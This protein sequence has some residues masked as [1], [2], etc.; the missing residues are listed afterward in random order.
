M[1]CGM[2][3]PRSTNVG[4]KS[5]LADN[6]PMIATFASR[7]KLWPLEE[8]SFATAFNTSAHSGRALPTMRA[9][10]RTT[11]VPSVRH[12]ATTL[13]TRLHALRPPSEMAHNRSW[14]AAGRNRNW[15][16]IFHFEVP[17]VARGVT[18]PAI[19]AATSLGV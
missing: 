5:A 2:F 7:A 10:A 9:S 18:A 17:S 16:L 13:G 14:R 8:H 15:I 19:D 12:L 11:D 6:G 3:R 1:G 4:T